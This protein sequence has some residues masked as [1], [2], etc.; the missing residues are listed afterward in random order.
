[1]LAPALRRPHPPAWSR[2]YTVGQ[3]AALYGLSSRAMGRL[4]A[5]G[6]IGHRRLNRQTYLVALAD[7]PAPEAARYRRLAD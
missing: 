2:A 3:L 7:L 5:R 4:L 1:M 6:A